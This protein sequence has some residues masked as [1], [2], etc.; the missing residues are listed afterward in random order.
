MALT[1]NRDVDRYVD[2]DI[3]EFPLKAAAHPYK[4]SFLGIEVATGY[5]RA[6]VAADVF[7]GIAYEEVDNSAGANGAKKVRSMVQ[8][9][10]EHALAGVTQTDMGVKVYASAD[11]TLTKTSASNSFVGFI[12]GI[13]AANMV[14]VRPYVLNPAV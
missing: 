1:A 14:L 4:G 5:V 7:A 12:I 2:N 13:P 6:L 3:R 10:F 9:D 11:D 8:G